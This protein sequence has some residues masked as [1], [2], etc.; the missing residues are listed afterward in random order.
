MAEAVGAR[1]FEIV[2]WGATG[3]TG[4]LVAEYL[5]ERHGA[6]GALRWAIGGRSRKRL[7]EMRAELAVRTGVP[8]DGLP[9]VT[10]DADDEASL[11]ALARRTAV[12]CT[13]VGP[14]GKHGSKL[15]AA[16]ARSGTHACDL[17][18][19]LP[20]IR[21]MIDAH[22]KEA[23]GSGARIVHSCG[24]D[25]IPSDLGV[26]FL[27]REIT[28]RDGAPAKR[29]RYRVAGFRGAYSGGTV[30]SV[31]NLLAEAEA[32]PSVRRIMADP[33]ALNPEGERHG[34]DGPDS[35]GPVFDE[36]FQQWTAPFLMAGINTRVVRRSN[37]LLGYPWSKE[38]RYDEA[39]LMGRGA[40]GWLRAAGFTAGLAAAMGAGSVGPLRRA[41]TR[42]LPAPGEGP[43]R[44]Q[45]EAGFFDIR[46]HAEPSRAGAAAMLARVT[47]DRD[48]GYGSTAKMLAESAL[49][50][51]R[52]P[53]V[54][55]GGFF[56]PTSAMGDLLI[57]RLETN[58]GLTFTIET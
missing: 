1:E 10:G 2:L 28:K 55:A 8:S 27:Q 34:P 30:A 19:E 5:L 13:T 18:G 11:E 32:D 6:G 7:E 54:A 24:F 16:C 40:L 9:I 42:F 58:A 52:D 46:L 48:P 51:A 49:C 44:D 15:V 17:T 45:R 56:T 33:Y 14:Y 22:E 3:F 43:S 20:W 37:A 31:L 12:V 4:R 36:V 39:T 26:H 41:L 38:F 57:A 25:S 50:L 21:R 47:G 53:L 23:Q 35:K 29:I